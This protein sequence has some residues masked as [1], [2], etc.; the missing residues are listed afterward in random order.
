M[1]STGRRNAAY[2]LAAVV[3]L[4][5]GYNV[6]RFHHLESSSSSSIDDFTLAKSESLDFFDDVPSKHWEL[7]KEKVA[8]QSPNY[9]SWALPHQDANGKERGDRRYK[10]YG[11]FYQNHYEPDFVC[12]HERRIGK[13]GDGGKWICDPHRISKQESC[14][15][16]SVGSNNDFS[17]EESVIKEIGKHCEIHTFDFG[18]YAE[19]AKQASERSGGVIHYHKT[20]LGSDKPPKYKSLATVVKELGHQGRT[21]DIFKIDCEKCEW[22][23]SNEWFDHSGITLRQI[24]VELHGADLQLTPK[25]FDLIYKNNYVITHKEANIA[26]GGA[27]EY[28]LLK[29][30]PKFHEEI[31]RPNGAMP[32]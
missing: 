19:G 10:K 18:N 5:I 3:L 1:P 6:G 16:Y 26:Y 7:L 8:W 20:F 25:F 21:V 15:V 9:N 23:T 24:Q 30:S 17:F 27:I 29:L 14:L 12:Q 28:A 13:I 22:S 4:C 11:M 31:V 2:L 32:E